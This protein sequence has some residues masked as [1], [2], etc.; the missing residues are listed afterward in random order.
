MPCRKRGFDSRWVLS[1][2]EQRS[3]RRSDKAE[4]V[5]S[6]PT[7]RTAMSLSLKRKRSSSLTLQAQT[8]DRRLRRALVEQRSARHVDIVEADG[9]NPSGSS[10][11]L[12]VQRQRCLAHI[13][14]TGVRFPPRPLFGLLVQQE[15]AALARRRS[16]CDSLAVH[17]ALELRYSTFDVRHS[18]FLGLFVEQKCRTSNVEYRMSNETCPGGERDIMPRS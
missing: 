8:G 9:S 12:V 10:D 7:G 1:P 18:I 4:I 15:D 11:G 2:V 5:G 6:N 16:G 3:A 14:E 17:C 13:Q